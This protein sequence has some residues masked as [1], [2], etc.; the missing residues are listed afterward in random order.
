M[1]G[2]LQEQIGPIIA[3]A[4]YCGVDRLGAVCRYSVQAAFPCKIGAC[5]V[6]ATRQ[7]ILV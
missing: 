6:H 4:I 3:V 2:Q 1:V 7:T 5:V